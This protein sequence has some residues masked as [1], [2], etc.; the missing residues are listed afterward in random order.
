VHTLYNCRAAT[1]ATASTVAATAVIAA[2]A[3]FP[4]ISTS[5]SSC[6]VTA[7]AAAAVYTAVAVDTAAAV[8]SAVTVAHYILNFFIIISL[9]DSFFFG[10][11]LP[12]PVA[13]TG[14]V[15]LLFGAVLY[16][17][18][19]TVLL[20]LVFAVQQFH[21]ENITTVVTHCSYCN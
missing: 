1:I 19:F 7:A 3:A 6:C 10:A 15:T 4:V 5:T 16:L 12:G 20:L 2:A 9:A 14:S 17:P 8:D 13:G 21:T 18:C 11:R